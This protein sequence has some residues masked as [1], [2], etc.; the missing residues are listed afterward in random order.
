MSAWWL[1]VGAAAGGLAALVFLY[2]P[3]AKSLPV[4]EPLAEAAPE[5]LIMADKLRVLDADTLIQI[6]DLQPPLA[7]IKAN[8]SLSDENWHKDAEPMLYA[9]IEFVQRLPASESHH[10]A[11]DG[12]LVR[13]TLDVAALALIAAAA[14]SWPP[15]AKTED[16]A[17]LSAVWRFGILVA[18]LLHDIGKT[19]TGFDVALFERA[20]ED[21]GTVWM[22]D[23]GSMLCS[24][25]RFYRVSFADTKAPYQAHASAAWAFFQ[26]IV[27]AH[28]RRWMAEADP[29][30]I[31]TL[32]QYLSGNTD[33]N[34]FSEIIKQADMASTARDLKSGSRQRFASAKRTPLIETVMD[35]LIDMLAERAAHFSI[36]VSAGGD[37]FRQGDLVYM[38]SKNVPD[39]IRQ[40]LRQHQHRA[41]AS[42]PSD[43]Q[44]IFD[45]LLEYGAVLPNPQDPRRAI[46]AV[47]VQFLRGDGE[48]K[49]QRFTMLVFKLATLYPQGDYPPE[50]AGSL[51]ISADQQSGKHHRDAVGTEMETETAETT[52]APTEAADTDTEAVGQVID[53]AT[54]HYAAPEAVPTISAV[55]A[56]AIPPP[57]WRRTPEAAPQAPKSAVDGKPAFMAVAETIGSNS[58]STEAATQTVTTP[59]ALSGIDALL[60][61][62]GL[63]TQQDDADTGAGAD[64][65]SVPASNKTPIAAQSPAVI[66]TVQAG[67]L[68]PKAAK[69]AP[70]QRSSKADLDLLKSLFGDG[71]TKPPASTQTAPALPAEDGAA[72]ALA[73]IQAEREALPTASPRPVTPSQNNLAELTQ[74]HDSTLMTA[75][76]AAVESIEAAPAS[77]QAPRQTGSSGGNHDAFAD[78]KKQRQ[79]TGR[80]FWNWLA[81][82]LEDGSITCN[83][84]GSPVHF[85]EQGMVLV[86]PGIFKAFAGGFFDRHN[87]ACPGLLAQ[88]GFV[89]LGLHQRT[90]KSAIYYA[91]AKKSNHQAQRK[92]FS[93]YLIPEAHV[94]HL[95][96][97]DRRPPNNIDMMISENPLEARPPQS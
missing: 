42:F 75:T 64:G 35:T 71:K 69:T 92:L 82:G 51:N 55:I 59:T 53:A 47:D 8:L 23:A 36:A 48:I 80:R 19:L 24:G 93:C 74:L 68:P 15:G 10:H 17:R 6:L 43:N 65:D 26:V 40:F 97:A 90:K 44:R 16:I 30:L 20:N 62:S 72:A 95:V 39:N 28:V 76:V 77:A 27:P 49:T 85:V 56:A 22:A 54:S 52:V 81:N 34:A 46:T 67:I 3:E 70:Q 84:S 83:Q 5:P 14:K 79:E 60:A 61:K 58:Q 7:N 33:K 11:G 4:E 32:K 41:A 96:K 86:T 25:R 73:E 9:Y 21:K 94:R 31:L 50:F 38:V 57:P 37:L 87:P 2:R 63:L 29:Q 88:Q 78:L 1:M 89:S 66:A 18:A 45:T 13:H 12:G 91:L